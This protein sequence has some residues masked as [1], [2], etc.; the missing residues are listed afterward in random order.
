[1]IGNTNNS[2]ILKL[3][4]DKTETIDVEIG[5][6]E[7][8]ECIPSPENKDHAIVITG[9]IYGNIEHDPGNYHQDFCAWEWMPF[10]YV[11]DWEFYGD[12]RIVD[13]EDKLIK[14]INYKDLVTKSLKTATV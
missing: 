12:I 8:E 13:E 5:Y 11:A 2:A 10:D 9:T 6:C 7:V 4:S 14:T 1:M 3:L